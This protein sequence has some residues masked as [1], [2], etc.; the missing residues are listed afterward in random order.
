MAVVNVVLSIILVRGLG[1]VGVA[2]GT[3]VALTSFSVFVLFPAACQRVELSVG[4][5]L[6]TA[7]WPAIWPAFVMAAML[8]I[9][10]HY[11]G[12]SLP[13]IFLQAIIAGLVYLAVFLM[14]AIGHQQRQWY[15]DK[16]RQLIKRPR[17]AVAA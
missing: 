10:R 7:V 1:L 2:L 9:T 3:L 13:A 12:A 17:T 8:A 4:K 6:A 16:V 14:L 11:V 5:A 15:L